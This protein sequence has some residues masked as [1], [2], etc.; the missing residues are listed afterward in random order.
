MDKI[1]ID[2]EKLL[3]T[4]GLNVRYEREKRK[5]KQEQLAEILDC[6]PVYIS[7]VENGKHKLSLTYALKFSL[8]FDKP[9][10]DLL[11]EK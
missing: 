9:L 1:T 11:K 8:Y 3:I 2:Q 10:E 5:L 6:S 7:N 4:F